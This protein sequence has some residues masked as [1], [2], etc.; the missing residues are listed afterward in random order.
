MNSN[1]YSADYSGSSGLH[2]AIVAIVAISSG[3]HAA[4]VARSSGLHAAISS[5][6][7]AAILDCMQSHFYCNK[8]L[9]LDCTSAIF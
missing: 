9:S 7:H 1:N 4:I 5:G 8:K 2:A 6:L 3:L